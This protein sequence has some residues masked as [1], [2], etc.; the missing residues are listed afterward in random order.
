MG[1][2]THLHKFDAAVAA[3]GI[4]PA[5]VRIAGGRHVLP[6]HTPHPTTTTTTP[7]PLP[8]QERPLLL[9]FKGAAYSLPPTHPAAARDRLAALHNGVD[10]I[11]A[12]TCTFPAVSCTC[13][14]VTHTSGCPPAEPTVTRTSSG[15]GC[16]E[17]DAQAEEWE[18]EELLLQARFTA[19]LPG[20][21]SHSYRL[22]EALQAG[23]IPVVLGESAL[24]LEHLLPWG[25]FAVVQRDVTPAALAQLPARLRAISPAM[26][27]Q[28]QQL[29]RIAF[30]S[31]FQDLNAQLLSLIAEAALMLRDEV[32]SSPSP[33]SPAPSPPPSTHPPA[34]APAPPATTGRFEP[35]LR[36]NVAQQQ[37]WRAEAEEH[38]RMLLAEANDTATD[39]HPATSGPPPDDSVGL[40]PT[41]HMRMQMRGAD[42][43]AGG[44]RG[45]LA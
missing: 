4:K 25:D 14:N 34:D 37:R 3:K 31:N 32:Q 1:D 6:L 39:D 16:N 35:S 15:A 30:T 33:A 36:T 17:M 20:E 2:F 38:V 44:G 19:V 40:L 18:F 24:P 13:V 22:Y 26:A 27:D 5:S 43:G 42:R 28:M 7:R 23:A 29:G 8:R 45:F 21:G 9:T 12:L 41:L 10:V 11:V